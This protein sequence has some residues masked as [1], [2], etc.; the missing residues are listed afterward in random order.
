MLQIQMSR[1][2]AVRPYTYVARPVLPLQVN[3][4][5]HKHPTQATCSHRNTHTKRHTHHVHK[6][7]VSKAW[8]GC[9]MQWKCSHR[10]TRLLCTAVRRQGFPGEVWEP[11]F[12]LSVEFEESKREACAQHNTEVHAENNKR[13]SHPVH[14]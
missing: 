6:L 9:Y 1:V 2:C 3:T 7:P 10:R 13:H 8:R 11:Y 5:V 12:S 14:T 4:R